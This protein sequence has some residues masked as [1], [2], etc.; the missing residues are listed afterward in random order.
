MKILVIDDEEMIR[1][2]AQKILTRAGFEVLTAES[3]YS[4][5]TL[6][7]EKPHQIDLVLV[8]LTMDDMPGV[9]TLR[10][11]REIRP[12]L[13]C[14]ISSGQTPTPD[15]LPDELNRNVRFLQKPYRAKQL[16]EMVDQ[17]LSEVG[18]QV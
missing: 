2:L 15:E 8:D 16:A 6:M 18:K 14:I 13:P 7:S 5:L 3:G 17:I 11:I 1:S 12:G 10:R 9:E 4:G